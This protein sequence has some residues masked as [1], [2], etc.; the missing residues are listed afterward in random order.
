MKRELKKINKKIEAMTPKQSLKDVL[1]E[2]ELAFL[3]KLNDNQNEAELKA[4]PSHNIY[5]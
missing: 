1:S 4:L 2:Q 3:R 5:R